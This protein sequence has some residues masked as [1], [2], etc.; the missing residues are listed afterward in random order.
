M[1]RRAPSLDV[2]PETTHPSVARRR[3]WPW[4]LALVLVA[5]GVWALFARSGARA[6]AGGEPAVK[7][8]A[9][10]V[11]VV[12]ATARQGD[13]PVYL[14]GLGSVAAFNT[15]TV[16]S[17]VDGQLVT[18]VFHEGQFVREGDVLAEVDPRP[19]A[20]QLTQAEGQMARDRAL[21]E[22]ARFT[23][24]RYRELYAQHV[25][26]KAELDDQAA[27]AGQYE[28][29]IGLDQ[30]LIDSAKLQL[31]YAHITAPISGR[32]GLRRVDVGNVIHATDP[33]GIV[34]ITQLQP[35]S[36]LFTLPEDNLPPIMKKLTAGEPLSVEAYDRANQNQ[37]ATGSLLTVDNQI[38]QSTGTTRLKA[39][40]PNEDSALFP[41][42][43]V[44][45][46]LLLDVKRG[47]VIVPVP[48]IQR[49][50]QGTFVYVVKPD[51]TVDVRPVSIGPTAGA[52]VAVESGVSADEVV[53]TDGVDKLR[54]GSAVRIRTPE[55]DATKP[56]PGA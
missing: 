29:M 3:R 11:P 23:L 32:A 31:T 35:V 26:A 54:A 36:V 22:D 7:T 56:K 33:N 21:L 24:A 4:L 20:V 40:F 42:Q 39:V 37:V 46:R 52:D 12:V 45:V 19:F 44:N 1:S 49:G 25:V 55:S 48:A 28:G 6:P 41:N 10:A 53:V 47:A 15:V 51:E 16:K 13:L 43:F 14:T 38:D 27:K 34:V 2:V 9:P 18:V 17:R 8:G 30:G 5:W 50:P